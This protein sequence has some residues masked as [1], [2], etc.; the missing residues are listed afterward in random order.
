MTLIRWKL[1]PKPSKSQ[2]KKSGFIP[3]KARWVIELSNAW[4][5]RC[6]SLVKN[7]ER[8]IRRGFRPLYNRAVESTS[9]TRQS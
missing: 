3:V 7:F 6:K 8:E 2:K 4:M 1:S 5:D 9:S